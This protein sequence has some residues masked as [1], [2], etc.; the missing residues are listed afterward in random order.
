MR[1]HAPRSR[2]LDEGLRGF[3]ETLM[4]A[5]EATP[6]HNPGNATLHH[7]SPGKDLEAPLGR[8]G[9]WLG[10]DQSLITSAAQTTHGLN[11]P[12]KM[13]FDPLKK[14]APVMTITPNHGKSG[15]EAF[16]W[17]KELFASRQV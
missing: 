1:K 9:L 14:L 10:L 15:Q 12:P 6:A 11:V 3:R 4:V 13:L 2:E 8:L 17:L 16:Q 5:S 7:P